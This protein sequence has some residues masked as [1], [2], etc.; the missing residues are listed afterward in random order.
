MGSNSKKIFSVIK[1]TLGLLLL[2]LIFKKIGVNEIYNKLASIQDPLLYLTVT[3]CIFIFTFLL[4]AINL[5]LLILPIKKITLL[6]LFRYSSITWAVGFLIPAAD[7]AS[8]S[9]FLKKENI[10]LGPGMAI[11]LLD[12]AITIIVTSILAVLGLF[13]LFPIGYALNLLL[14]LS[15]GLLV[16]LFLISPLGRRCIIKF[17]LRGHSKKFGGFYNTLKWYLLNKK[18]LLILNACVT[19]IKFVITALITY[20][21]L[22]A[23]GEKASLINVILILAT[24]TIL[25]SIPSPLKF[26]GLRE[27]VYVSIAIILYNRVGLSSPTIIGVSVITLLMCYLYALLTIMFIDYKTT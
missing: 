21:L 26:I 11:N 7:I 1:V 15:V 9:Y 2:Y 18:Y 17:V 23:F 8:L 19:T 3:F 24:L 25:Q 6:R 16:L 20:L 12:K 10:D 27:G 5:Y 22:S 13:K 14:L 4:S